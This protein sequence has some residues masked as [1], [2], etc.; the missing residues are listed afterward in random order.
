MGNRAKF[1]DQWRVKL[2][3]SKIKGPFP[4]E[5]INKM[6]VEGIL[7]GQEEVAQYPDGDWK[8]LDKQ[9]EFYE[10]LLESL[11][12]PVER[13]EKKAQK[14]EAETVVQKT[15]VKPSP[16]D[17]LN[18]NSEEVPSSELQNDFKQLVEN[19]KNNQINPL[20]KPIPGLPQEDEA[21]KKGAQD[22]AALAL[23]K[24]RDEQLTIEMNQLKKVQAR[25]F[26][27]F[28]PFISIIILITGLI[29]Y[30]LT[31]S[32][33]QK[34][35]WVLIAPNRE[36]AVEALSAQETKSLKQKTIALLKSG[37]LENARAS[38]KFI[39]QVIE[40]NP[41]DLE[42]MGL[43]CVI[44]E[45]IWPYTK[46]T[47]QDIKAVT[48]V[49]QMVRTL[50]PVSSYSDTCQSVFM[51]TKGQP[52]DARGLIEKTL[53]HNTEE[54]FILYPFLYYIKGQILE[55]SQNYLN[56]EA[57][58]S[59][60]IKSFPGWNWA[61]FA[62]ART[63]YKQD[64]FTEAKQTYES[65]LR[66]SPD[67]KGAL[68]GVGL[69]ELKLGVSPDRALQYFDKAYA[70][71]AV[72]PKIFHLEALQEYVKLLLNKGDSSKALE[73]A[74]FGLTISPTHR[75]LKEVVISLGGE[76]KNNNASSELVFTGDQFAR[77]GDH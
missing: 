75:A 53:D 66:V 3:N 1:N 23:L 71:N 21:K 8:P 17:P 34:S 19:E 77:S 54:R 62:Q 15:T 18:F 49:T 63:F 59:E 68:Y 31:E 13:D 60:A 5:A 26:K 47:T 44:Y 4:T 46:Q 43:L 35:G 50:N 56:A 33:V 25:E 67:Y 40:S 48:T 55:E 11:E 39:V 41:K 51:L 72:L 58:Y 14:M 29:F 57:Y 73:V 37:T 32:D 27:K 9:G 76:D 12:N 10:A 28:V 7:S 69:S 2:E 38:Q 20:L 30:F 36:N 52:K 65:I 45:Q 42:A 16:L 22:A 6:I 24:A 64:K 61:S 74:Q 70:I